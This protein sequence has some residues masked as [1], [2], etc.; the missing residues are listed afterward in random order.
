[1]KERSSFADSASVDVVDVEI[2]FRADS[3]SL[4]AV[5]GKSLRP[6]RDEISESACREKSTENRRRIRLLVCRDVTDTSAQRYDEKTMYS[7][8]KADNCIPS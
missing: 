8:F 6:D 3:A 5:S 1:M 7:A 4:A 2:E